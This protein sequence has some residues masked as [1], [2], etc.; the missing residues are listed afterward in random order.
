MTRHHKFWTEGEIELLHKL[1]ASGKT[2]DEIADILGRTPEAIKLKAHRT[3]ATVS[4]QRYLSEDEYNTMLAD[5]SAYPLHTPYM[6]IEAD[7]REKY[8]LDGIRGTSVGFVSYLARR[9]IIRKRIR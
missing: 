6:Q 4:T 7:M 1:A 5:I 2:V 8:N 9:G 3:D